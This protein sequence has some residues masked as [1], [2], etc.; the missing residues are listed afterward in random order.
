MMMQTGT[1]SQMFSV[2]NT[3]WPLPYPMKPYELTIHP[4]FLSST[5]RGL[6]VQYGHH[7]SRGSKKSLETYPLDSIQYDPLPPTKTMKTKSDTFT[8]DAIL[9]RPKTAD[10]MSYSDTEDKFLP[11]YGTEQCNVL[12]HRE[13]RVPESGHP[14]LRQSNYDGKNSYRGHLSPP[15]FKQIS[16]DLDKDKQ[17]KKT[18]DGWKSS[19]GKRVRTIF[20][21]EQL[22]RLEAEFERQQYMVGTER[23]YLASSLNLTE[24]QVKVWFQ[25]RRIKW[26]KQHLEQQQ[27]KLKSINLYKD[28]ESDESEAESDTDKEQ[29]LENLTSGSATLQNPFTSS[30]EMRYT[31]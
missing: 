20:T 25:N 4:A 12:K 21:P 26:R 31:Q 17:E 19:K 28:V 15:H 18:S 22:E 23:F 14:Y 29:N 3:M 7:T 13:R 30:K 5:Y 6:P 10:M 11:A 27:A 24:A 1:V 8:I 2:P 9:N 16:Q